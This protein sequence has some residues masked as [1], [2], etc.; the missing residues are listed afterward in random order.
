[1]GV[2]AIRDETLTGSIMHELMLRFDAE[3][4]TVE[5]LIA[6]RIKSEVE[7]HQNHLQDKLTQYKEKVAI[8]KNH[9][10]LPSDLENRINNKKP[11]PIDVQKQIDTA[12]KAF[13]SNGFLLL[14]DDEQA[15]SLK[16]KVQVSDKTVVSFIKMT[17]LVGG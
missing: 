13:N 9:L 8:Y 4:I 7:R 14:I 12:I 17:P 5:E 6:S 1:M 3:T 10:V 2:L 16:Q 15:V 11:K